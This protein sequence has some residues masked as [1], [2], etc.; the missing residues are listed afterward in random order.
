MAATVVTRDPIFNW[1]AYGGT[2][3]M[4]KDALRVIPRDGLRQRFIA[5]VGDSAKPD[6]NLRRLKLELD[7]D[8]FA[9][10]Q[11]IVMDESLGKLSFTLENRTKDQHITGLWL[12][13]PEGT[14]YQV[15]QNGK[16]VALGKT[17]N[18]DYPLMAEI[19][20]GDGPSKIEITRMSGR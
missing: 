17:G 18:W 14:E 20:T 15:T 10:G 19:K 12:S 16:K 8:G 2:L 1:L 9:A 11:G 4:K 13:V 3:T 5:I 6:T 7:R